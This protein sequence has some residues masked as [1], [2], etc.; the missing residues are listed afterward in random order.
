MSGSCDLFDFIGLG[1]RTD[2]EDCG[3]LLTAWLRDG[4]ATADAHASTGSAITA[5]YRWQWRRTGV[6]VLGIGAAGNLVSAIWLQPLLFNVAVAGGL[7]VFAARRAGSRRGPD[8]PSPECPRLTSCSRNARRR[9][10][11]AR[12][13]VHLTSQPQSDNDAR[14]RDVRASENAG[15]LHAVLAT[16]A[17]SRQRER[18][19]WRRWRAVS[20][21]AVPR[22][23]GGSRL[24]RSWRAAA[25]ALLGAGREPAGRPGRRP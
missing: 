6:I 16:V 11:P 17:V 7:S 13:A 10:R 2:V 3:T 8:S 15:S 1:T 5:P 22:S 12:P 18:S 14:H 25:K 19:L 23:A 4:R 24:P 21:P 20:R 9:R